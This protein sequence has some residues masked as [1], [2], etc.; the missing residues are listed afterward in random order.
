VSTR[1]ARFAALAA[2]LLLLLT[3]GGE[4]SASGQDLS[5]ALSSAESKVLGAE[6]KI[7][8]LEA[9]LEAAKSRYAA[10]SQVA[11]PARAASRSAQVKARD[12]KAGIAAAQ[13]QAKARIAQLEAAHRQEADRHDD[14]VRNGIGFGL[15]ALVAATIALGWD[16][17]RASAAVAALAEQTLGRAIGLCVGGGFMMLIVGAALGGTGGL[18]GV[19]GSFI[20]FLGFVLPTALLLG[21]HSAEVQRG[22]AK[23]LLRHERLPVLV[24]RTVAGL[25]LIVFLVGLGKALFSNGPDAEA[26]SARLTRTAEGGSAADAGELAATE[27]R[28]S[29]LRKRVAA[30]LAEQA[31]ARHAVSETS[32]RLHGAEH[33]LARAEAGTRYF[34]RRLAVVTAREEREAART[35]LVAE[36]QY[37]K[38]IE[39]ANEEEAEFEEESS[40]CDPNYTG[41]VPNTGYDVDCAEVSGPVEVIGVD[42]DGLDADSDGIGCE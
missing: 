20:F 30:P 33:Q 6:D 25:A 21:R 41:C 29:R 14:Q 3:I 5:A 19:I 34:T 38:E 10:A 2:A 32:G 39:E 27:V 40:G 42:V 7:G 1:W 12:L 4:G 36:R 28:A 23:P 22:R 13:R 16:W 26:L 31:A 9:D 24:L 35:A 37:Q 17:F 8:G 11:D 15:A 18:V